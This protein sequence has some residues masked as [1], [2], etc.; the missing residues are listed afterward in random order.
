MRVYIAGPVT[1]IEDDNKG[2]FT[3]AAW[4]LVEMGHEPIVPHDYVGPDTPWSDAMRIC[5]GQLAWCDAI[6]LLE[7]WQK[8]KGA[9]LEATI[10]KQ[11]GMSVVTPIAS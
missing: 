2:A 10:A 3:W 6:M 4:K 9:R 11:L 1:G 5:I 8:S 7:G